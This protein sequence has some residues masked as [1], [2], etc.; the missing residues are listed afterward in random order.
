[1]RGWWID[2]SSM[3]NIALIIKNWNR[4]LYA[5]SLRNILTIIEELVVM[6]SVMF[7]SNWGLKSPATVVSLRYL[8]F[9]SAQ[10]YC[11]YFMIWKNRVYFKLLSVSITVFKFAG[12]PRHGYGRHP[13]GTL[14]IG[15]AARIFDQ[16]WHGARCCHWGF[17]PHRIW[18]RT[19]K[20]SLKDPDRFVP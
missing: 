10:S 2:N 5:S 16:K 19:G 13:C 9:F 7:V 15:C 17:W 20:L 14:R 18:M 1:M 12:F 8:G 4:P 11:C 3:C 6:V